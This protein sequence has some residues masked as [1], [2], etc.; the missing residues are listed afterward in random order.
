MSES[1][2]NSR[3]CAARF[4]A[5]KGIGEFFN[6]TKIAVNFI[7][8]APKDGPSA[9]AA[10]SIALLSLAQ[11]LPITPN[12]AITGSIDLNLRIGR[13]GGIREKVTAAK[14]SEIT[15]VCLPQGNKADWDDL[16]A[17]VRKDMTPVF[18][19]TL[20]ELFAVAFE[21]GTPASIEPSAETPCADIAK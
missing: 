15:R 21:K 8:A 17:E 13:V 5:E 7:G 1:V 9:G 6:K 16:P 11:S 4:A 2:R 10:I 19:K 18:V 20:A 3:L 14:T 12:L